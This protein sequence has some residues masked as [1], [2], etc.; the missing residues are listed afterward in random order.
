MKQTLIHES[1]HVIIIELLMSC[2][3]MVRA[4]AGIFLLYFFSAFIYLGKM[5]INGKKNR[6]GIEM[7]D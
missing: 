2:L 5:D 1:E 4:L 6:Y 7:K 3:T